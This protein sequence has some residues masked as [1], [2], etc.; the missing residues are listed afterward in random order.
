MASLG[1]EVAPGEA[2]SLL[3]PVDT[4]GG[5]GERC[6]PLSHSLTRPY[7][8]PPCSGS[9]PRCVQ[10]MQNARKDAACT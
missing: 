8:T 3:S 2:T 7:P 4:R 10:S 5:H 1:D 6:T 9:N